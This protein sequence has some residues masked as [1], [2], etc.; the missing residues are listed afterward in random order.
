MP[1]W[2]VRRALRCSSREIRSAFVNIS[3]DSYLQ[4]VADPNDPPQITSTPVA[5]ATQDLLY[6]YD[7]EATDPDVADTLTF[8]LDVSPAGMAIDG[9]TGLIT[10]TPTSSQTGDNSVIV[11]VA[12]A[13]LLFATQTLVITVSHRP[14]H[15]VDAGGTHLVHSH[16]CLTTTLVILGAKQSSKGKT[17]GDRRGS[18]TVSGELADKY[19]TVR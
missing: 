9:A 19:A 2:Q 1:F 16:G 7:V 10:W 17:V 14:V 11:R 13:A 18:A 3:S 4:L 8:S 6:S 15:R 5:S 12:D